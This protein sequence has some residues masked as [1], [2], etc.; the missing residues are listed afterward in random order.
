MKILSRIG[1]AVALVVVLVLL[2]DTFGGYF[3]DGPL[4]PIPGGPLQG[5]VESTARPDWSGIEDVIEIEIRPDKP[6]SLSVWNA[7]IDGEL[8]IPSA[9]GAKRRWPAVA[10]AD[11]RVRVR[12][13]GKIYERRIVKVEDG[14]LRSRIAKAITERYGSGG[15]DTSWYF[16]LAPR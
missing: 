3:L 5:Q 7:V 11:P 2:L 15:S 13:G 6:W 14:A 1:V 12:T 10:L 8:Y 4:G 16:H 9:M